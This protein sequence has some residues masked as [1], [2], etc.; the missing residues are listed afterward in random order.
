MSAIVKIT[1]VKTTEWERKRIR[2]DVIY[3]HAG[4][5]WSIQK[6]RMGDAK[7]QWFQATYVGPERS[8]P[9]LMPKREKLR[10]AQLD[11]LSAIRA[12]EEATSARDRAIRAQR[13]GNTTLMIDCIFDYI[14]EELQKL[15]W[16]LDD[17]LDSLR[18]SSS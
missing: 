5:Q 3:Y 10:E 7:R 17:R 15:K 13:D 1:S 9:G 8:A 18:I 4:G 2:G 6:V 14:D 12:A 11:A 16:E